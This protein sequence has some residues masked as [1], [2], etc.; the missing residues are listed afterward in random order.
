MAKEMT[1]ERQ[2]K[3]LAAQSLRPAWRAL[4]AQ[5]WLLQVRARLEIQAALAS[6]AQDYVSRLQ[7]RITEN[8]TWIEDQL[9]AQG[10][11][12]ESNQS[13]GK[14]QSTVFNIMDEL[15]KGGEPVTAQ[16]LNSALIERGDEALPKVKAAGYV[17][18]Y[19]LMKN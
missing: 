5:Q 4:A 10:S 6:R 16:S 14:Q 18:Q 19:K 8:Q 2:P 9:A 1:S 3:A 11:P 17:T 13:R 12:V 7:N 15:A